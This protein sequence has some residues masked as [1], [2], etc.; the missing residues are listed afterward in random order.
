MMFSKNLRYLR[1][2]K[3]WSK[4]TLA[5]KLGYKSFTTI[6]KWETGSSEPS[7]S[8]VK[9]ISSIFGVTMDNLINSDMQEN[10]DKVPKLVHYEKKANLP[11]AEEK[12]LTLYRKLN[13]A[14]QLKVCEYTSDL[15]ASG[16]YAESKEVDFLTPV[17]A[18][19]SSYKEISE[20]DIKHDLDL[21]NDDDF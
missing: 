10:C 18:H 1:K 7:V 12:I 19:H 21:L 13:E 8:I 20:E 5:E 3:G 4:E 9:E 15:V 14:G 17:A 2:K 6:Q 16:N 11:Q